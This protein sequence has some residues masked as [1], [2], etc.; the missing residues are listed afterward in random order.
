M[1][2]ELSIPLPNAAIAETLFRVLAVDP[3]PPR[4]QVEK[5]LRLERNVLIVTF[6]SGNA[7]SLNTSF[8]S[9]VEMFSLSART[10]RECTWHLSQ[11]VLYIRLGFMVN[12]R[13]ALVKIGVKKMNTEMQAFRDFLSTYNMLTQHC[14]NRCIFDF[15]GRALKSEEES[16][17]Y[18]CVQKSVHVN[19]RLV[20]AF[21]SMNAL[22]QERK[23]TERT[24]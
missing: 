6:A 14:F 7:K 23:S 8:T 4:S 13:W 12:Y 16:C 15:N 10:R 11:S 18:R 20:V 19:R 2:I 9:F 21:A 5:T 24:S 22:A 1:Q 17:I 3:E